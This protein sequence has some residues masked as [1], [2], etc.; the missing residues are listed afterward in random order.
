MLTLHLPRTTHLG[1]SRSLGLSLAPVANINRTSVR[2][3]VKTNSVAI[4][5]SALTSRIDTPRSQH[6]LYHHLSPLIA[7][8]P[9]SELFA[10]APFC[11]LIIFWCTHRVDRWC[12]PALGRSTIHNV[13]RGIL[14]PNGRHSAEPSHGKIDTL[15]KF[16][17][18]GA[19]EVSATLPTCTCISS[20]HVYVRRFR[21]IVVSALFILFLHLTLTRCLSS[22]PGRR[23]PYPF[24]GLGRWLNHHERRWL[25]RCRGRYRI[26][27]VVLGI[28]LALG[29]WRWC[30]AGS[31]LPGNWLPHG[32]PL[33][34]RG[35]PPWP[36]AAF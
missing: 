20:P 13:L 2:C 26:R 3:I 19:T 28:V 24:M 12:F 11:S 30:S 21:W 32:P 25:W 15:A 7:S 8:P 14:P 4:C 23:R 36:P 17:T 9:V 33:R 29:R 27:L 6:S 1:L 35:H 31:R 34:S 18:C 10:H 5:A 16:A 22:H